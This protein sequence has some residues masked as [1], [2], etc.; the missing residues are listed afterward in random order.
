[1]TLTAGVNVIKFLLF[2]EALV[3][4]KRVMLVAGM[5]RFARDKSSSLTASVKKNFLNNYDCL[6]QC[7]KLFSSS[8]AMKP[9]KLD[10]LSLAHLFSLV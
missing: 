7:Y 5:E 1:M 10:C 2:S 3:Q 9:N 8:T 6:G 4:I